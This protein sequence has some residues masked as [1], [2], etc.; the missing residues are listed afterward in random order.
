MVELELPS[1]DVCELPELTERLLK[2][3]EAVD[4][5]TDMG[6]RIKACREFIGAVL[7]R[8]AVE[9]MVGA[10]DLREAGVPRMFTAY[11]RIKAAYWREF[12]AEQRAELDAQME[13]L[14]DVPRLVEAIA[15]ITQAPSSRQVFRAVK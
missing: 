1:G 9:P 4:K 11:H 12:N 2:K 15:K 8:E 10:T 7:P 13:P 5:A 14:R 3:Q 6:E